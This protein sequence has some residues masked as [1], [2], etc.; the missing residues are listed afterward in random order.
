MTN[1][2]SATGDS[3]RPF[4]P[5]R[6]PHLFALAAIFAL[7]VTYGSLVPLDFHPM[8]SRQVAQQVDQVLQESLDLRSRSDLLVNGSLGVVLGFLLMAGFCADRSR[9][10]VLAA[11]PVAVAVCVLFAAVIEFAQLFFPPRVSSLTDIIAGHWFML[12]CSGLG[13]HWPGDDRLVP[14]GQTGQHGPRLGRPALA[15]LR[16]LADPLTHGAF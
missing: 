3:P 4:L 1:S 12:W 15:E 14:P 16:V 7:I 8:P 11:A 2:R 6:R 9:T 5:P 13:A 10:A